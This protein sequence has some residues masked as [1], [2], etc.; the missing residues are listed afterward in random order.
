MMVLMKDSTSSTISRMEL[1]LCLEDMG[2][3]MLVDEGR[4]DK[5]T[6]VMF[7]GHSISNPDLVL[8][9][10]IWGA[11]YARGSPKSYSNYAISKEYLASMHC[12]LVFCTI[13]LHGY[14]RTN[15]WRAR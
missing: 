2:P 13:N 12:V 3:R 1:C 14:W 5:D 9:P 10:H 8:E 7:D 6:A 4:T 15:R 11:C